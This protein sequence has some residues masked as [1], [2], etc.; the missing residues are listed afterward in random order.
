MSGGDDLVMMVGDK[1]GLFEDPPGIGYHRR[2]SIGLLMAG[3]TGVA[4]PVSMGLRD[5][6]G[7]RRT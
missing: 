7:G 4:E 5:L 6:T 2:E 3:V 1:F